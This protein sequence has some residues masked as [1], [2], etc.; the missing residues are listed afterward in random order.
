MAVG[1]RRRGDGKVGQEEG[2]PEGQEGARERG[3]AAR[4][5]RTMSDNGVAPA[6]RRRRG[7]DRRMI[8]ILYLSY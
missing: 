4:I 1:Q 2:G 6:T 8:L 3:G 7:V 5:T